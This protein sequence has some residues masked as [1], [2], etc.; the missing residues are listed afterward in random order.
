ML[1][2][3]SAAGKSGIADVVR[4]SAI[5]YHNQIKREFWQSVFVAFIAAPSTS[6]IS[7]ID[8]ADSAVKQWEKRF[9]ME[10]P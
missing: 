6:L 1:T 5:A 2:G 4:K 7:A 10:A 3:M 9:P 8:A